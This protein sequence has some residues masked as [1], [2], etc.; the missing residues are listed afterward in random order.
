M[1]QIAKPP[2]EAASPAG[3]WN[4]PMHQIVVVLL[5]FRDTVK[6]YKGL[7]LRLLAAFLGALVAGT[8]AFYF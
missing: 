5:I 1:L 6:R 4:L 3:R 8:V 2:D 7:I